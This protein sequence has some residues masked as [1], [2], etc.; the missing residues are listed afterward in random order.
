MLLLLLL[1]LLLASFL[2]SR[3]LRGLF[4]HKKKSE[5]EEVLALQ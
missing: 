3:V 1:L 4:S 2:S 5:R